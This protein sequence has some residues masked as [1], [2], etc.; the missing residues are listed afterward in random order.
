MDRRTRKVKTNWKPDGYW[1]AMVLA[2]FLALAI[3]VS[4]ASDFGQSWDEEGDSAYGA[5]ALSSY[6]G[7]GPDWQAYNKRKFYGPAHFMLQALAVDSS[8]KGGTGWSDTRVRHTLNFLIF[9]IAVLSFHYI[10]RARVSRPAA[11]GA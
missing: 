7:V 11:L 10:A 4:V 6:R 3:G 8:E 2:C 1:I 5:D 9:P